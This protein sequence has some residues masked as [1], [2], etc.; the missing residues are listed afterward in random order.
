MNKIIILVFVCVLLILILLNTTKLSETFSGNIRSI[1]FIDRNDAYKIIDSISTFN[2]YNKL[3]LKLRDIDNVNNIK[4]H[5][6]TALLDWQI[7]DKKIMNWLFEIVIQK[8]PKQYLFL[9]SNIKIAKFS[10]GI[11][12]D[13]PH[14]NKDT[15]FITNKFIET[16]LS[17]Y[18]N[19]DSEGAIK[20]I[21]SVLIHECIHIWQRRDPDFFIELYKLWGFRYSR[22]IYNFNKIIKNSRYNPD[23]VELTWIYTSPDKSITILPGALYTDNAKTIGDVNLVGIRCEW[24]G[25]NPAIPPIYNLELLSDIKIYNDEFGGLYP[26]NY[27]PNEIAAEMISKYIIDLMYPLSSEERYSSISLQKYKTFFNSR[28]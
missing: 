12:K 20:Q 26:N 24:I 5:Y 13:F 7:H 9:F 25:N 17:Y 15:I 18:N 4:R 22:R 11:E 2:S 27:H 14:T 19:K 1:T 28:Y 21:G 10:D 23:G 16:I 8:I 6:K 3:D